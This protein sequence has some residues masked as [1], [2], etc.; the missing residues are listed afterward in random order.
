MATHFCRNSSAGIMAQPRMSKL[1]Q[2]NYGRTLVARILSP[3]NYGN[4]PVPKF[5]YG[6]NYG[7]TSTVEITCCQNYDSNLVPK[8]T[9]RGDYGKTLVAEILLPVNYG[10]NPMPKFTHGKNYGTT[11]AAIIQNVDISTAFLRT[12]HPQSFSQRKRS[13]LIQLLSA[14]FRHRFC[15]LSHILAFGILAFAMTKFVCGL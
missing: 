2:G 13:Q 5:T 9:H 8:F 12:R 11:P 15:H 3:V 1:G 7:K 6:K 4:N 10:N 14:E